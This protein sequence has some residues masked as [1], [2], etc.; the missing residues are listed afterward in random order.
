[1]SDTFDTPGPSLDLVIQQ[2][3][4]LSQ[5]QN[6]CK[7][8]SLMICVVLLAELRDSALWLLPGGFLDDAHNLSTEPKLVSSQVVGS[9]AS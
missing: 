6:L 5:R 2:L 9:Q 4:S 8:H 1:M 3:N 7:R